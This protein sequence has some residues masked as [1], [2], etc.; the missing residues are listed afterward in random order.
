MTTGPFIR[1]TLAPP[2]PCWIVRRPPGDNAIEIVFVGHANRAE[3]ESKIERIARWSWPLDEDGEAMILADSH[4]DPI[5]V[6]LVR[7]DKNLHLG[8]V[9]RAVFDLGG[10]AI[11][12]EQTSNIWRETVIPTDRT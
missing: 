9:V 8:A 2:A 4:A 12:A 7:P 5:G 3:L 11:F 1:P 6:R 10:G